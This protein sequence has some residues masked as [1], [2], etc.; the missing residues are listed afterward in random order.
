MAS[1]AV[2]FFM[3]SAIRP[4]CISYKQG[5]YREMENVYEMRDILQERLQEL[6]TRISERGD[7]ERE[8]KMHD[9][10]DKLARG[11]TDYT[12]CGH[13][14]AGKSSLINRLCGAAILPSSPIPTSANVV[15][16]ENGEERVIIERM[17]AEASQT[18][19]AELDEACRNGI[20]I[21]RIHIRYPVPMLMDSARLL[22][23]PG[24][25]STDD[26]HRKATEDALHMADAVFYVMD[27]NH[28][29]SE[30]NFG[31]IRRLKEFGKPLFLIVN[32][33][34]KHRAQELTF[35]SF[36]EKVQEALQDWQLH[37]EGLFFV[38]VKKPDDPN[39]E[40]PYLERMLAR[41][42]SASES[43]LIHGVRQAVQQ[44]IREHERWLRDEEEAER[45]QIE[46]AI[47]RQRAAS[48]T[49]DEVAE[50]Q[51]LSAEEE[52]RG[53]HEAWSQMGDSAKKELQRIL[54]Q[55]N[56]IPAPS[57]DIAHQYLASR[58]SGF[59]V[60]LLFSE[61]KT[62]AE[63]ERRLRA[64][65][66]EV[67][68]QADAQIRWHVV[69]YVKRFVQVW[70][71]EPE[72]SEAAAT[73][74][75]H[76]RFDIT[77]GWL[78]SL[79]QHGHYDDAYTLQYART[80]A[81]QIRLEYRRLA[82][83]A[84]EQLQQLLRSE[85]ERRVTALEERLH[86]MGM[87]NAAQRELDDMERRLAAY[88]ARLDA[89]FSELDRVPYLTIDQLLGELADELYDHRLR[90]AKD[91]QTIEKG[92]DHRVSKQSPDS[93]PPLRSVADDRVQGAQ[94]K[95]REA[96][97]RLRKTSELLHD[98]PMFSGFSRTLIDKAERLERNQYTIALFGAFS[99]GKSS[100]AN[101]LLH[102]RALPVS[103]NPTTAAINSVKPLTKED[104]HGQAVLHYKSRE[105]MVADV[106]L[107]LEKLHITMPESD[108][109]LL[110]VIER[111]DLRQAAAGAKVHVAFLQAVRSGWEQFHT[112]LGRQETVDTEMYRRAV[113]D[114]TQAC[115]LESVE[116]YVDSAFAKQGMILVDTPG[117]D[118][119]NAR[120]TDVA[121]NYIKNADAILF[122]TYYNHAF[123][124]AD[125]E[126]LL[127]LGRV[128]D[129]FALNKMFFIVNAADLASDEEELV[130]VVDHVRTNLE[131]FGIREPRI[132]PVSSM[133]ALHSLE[134]EDE[135]AYEISG[136]KTFE[137]DFYAFVHR[138]LADMSIHSGEAELLRCRAALAD[139]IAT[140]KEAQSDRATQS[141]Q[142]ELGLAT[143]TE[144]LRDGVSKRRIDDLHKEIQELI[145]YAAQR[146]SFRFGELYNLAFNPSSFAD[147]AI[148]EK[149]RLANAYEELLQ[150]MSFDLS[151]E[152]RATTLRIETFM[153]RLLS[154]AYDGW[155]TSLHTILQGFTPPQRDMLEW[156]RPVCEVGLEQQQE[157]WKAIRSSYR[158]NRQFFEQ[159]GKMALKNTL[160]TLLQDRMKRTALSE[161]Q[162]FIEHYQQ[163][164]ATAAERM[165]SSLQEEATKYTEAML[166]A[167]QSDVEL[168]QYEHRLQAMDELAKNV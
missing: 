46:A 111:A 56:V 114:E 118:S 96:A 157:E 92:Y 101:A 133:N 73:I 85:Y 113:A 37:P 41:L 95:L 135:V 153:D 83:D 21:R 51:T 34:D 14:S 136:M 147:A 162:Q 40:W 164:F 38:S 69:D 146:V 105:A 26:L 76:I 126:F 36:R 88:I 93:P 117:A 75:D 149:D 22:D 81:D 89:M 134:A 168:S 145:Y 115:F 140:M 4:A 66:D 155:S 13:F 131:V 24:V 144:L 159:D 112:K 9:L 128:K 27:Y 55:A 67:V 137:T 62:A 94:S 57:R 30:M 53:W 45:S 20:D 167:L 99:A 28:V 148:S 71:L 39:N 130:Q 1:N 120:H 143:A 64:W 12:F 132:Y 50:Q 104:Q 52:L 158:N 25:D 116:L 142:I 33:I 119:I 100:F 29:L 10:L 160:D 161:Q 124:H 123:S 74:I 103:P 127:Q 5:L 156:E 109:D 87:R 59:R 2:G 91:D 17:Q 90:T 42:V 70:Q 44:I 19:V 163:A 47:E 43:L 129:M 7:A 150:Y 125:R 63:Q 80:V 106:R 65:C 18:T 6:M 139:W 98:M 107:S 49:A 16:I 23:T 78:A 32:Q 8:E 152:L 154:E 79:V 110:Q 82:W 151:Q 11:K 58:R 108:S 97:S 141:R 68:Q 54:D 166:Q 3:M 102:T 60:G 138:E 61:R 31:Y 15:T 165:A 86:A 84:L 77:D 122:V 48:D 121:F 72:M 35:A